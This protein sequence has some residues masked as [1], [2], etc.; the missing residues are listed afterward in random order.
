MDQEKA[1]NYNQY[2]A[3]V[4]SDI[5]E[6]LNIKDKEVTT[7]ST[8]FKFVPESED[9]VSKLIDRIRNVVA[10]GEDGI[11]ARALKDGKA[12]LVPILTKIINIGYEV[13]EFPDQLKGAIVKPIHKKECHNT[14]SN[15]RP[16]SI[17]P[18]ISKV[19]ERSAVDQL[20]KYL[21]TGILS[22]SQHA[23][24]KGHST[25]TCLA[26]VTNTIYRSLDN[27]L[28]VAIISM[29]LSKAF[30]AICHSH[31]LQKLSDM[32]LHNN[33]VSWVK[34]YLQSRKQKTR[35]KNVT[36]EESLVTSGVPQGSIL[37][38]IL[39]LCFTNELTNSFPEAKVVSY[40]D[41]TQF[42][43]TGKSMESVK[44]KAEQLIERAETWYRSNSLMSNPSKTELIVF[45][46]TKYNGNLLT[47]SSTENGRKFN[48]EASD[49]LKILGVHI[50]RDMSWKTHI[51]KLRS[52]TI[53]IVKHLHRINK[54][55]PMRSKLQL[56]DSLVASHLNYADVIWSGCTLEN[57]QKLQTVQN[58][59]LK[60]ILGKKKSDSATEALQ[61]LKYLN[62]EEKRKIHEA[63]YTHKILAGKMPKNITKDYN[64][65]NSR[66]NHRSTEKSVL[67]IPIHKSS[68]YE[69]SVLYRTVKTWNAIDPELKK[70]ETPS[71]K[72]SL[73]AQMIN[74][75]HRL[76]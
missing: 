55:L 39:F 53:G 49:S 60:S 17:L 67:N 31:L 6:K 22:G 19:F 46:P 47:V 54:L 69:N 43:I 18:I 26:E 21:E 4:G 25:V 35:F 32:G 11:N 48:L 41:D 37:G 44:Q 42:I 36:S 65:L 14:P 38:P 20:V 52:K 13:N 57:K 63:V 12:V 15:Y 73:Q 16:I 71:F 56:Y 29:D 51:S 7:E 45:T 72:R 50:D 23:Y 3:T 74:S 28:I 59:A 2:F 24:R 1:N 68:R 40:A 5:K 9:N 34:S 75:K 76:T 70:K 30:D 33:A 27:G 8:G 61:T 62:L 66:L 58:F 10:V 64:E